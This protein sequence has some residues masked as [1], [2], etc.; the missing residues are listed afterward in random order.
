MPNNANAPD[1]ISWAAQQN[2]LNPSLV[3]S[4]IRAESSGNPNAVSPA[5]AQGLM[6]LM[7]GTARDLGVTN[8][9][10][11][12]D[13]AMGGI[14]YLG[15]MNSQ[16]GGD[17]DK[18]LAAYNFGP[19]N[20]SKGRAYPP[21]TQAYIQKVN[22][23]MQQ[24]GGSQSPSAEPPD[25]LDWA[26]TQNQETPAEQ[27]YS[28]AGFGEN[29]KSSAG[30]FLENLVHPITH[31]GE[32]VTGLKNLGLGVGEKLLPGE[33]EHEK[34]ANA[35]G[36]FYADR[37]GGLEKIQ[38]TLYTDPVGAAADVSM[39]FGGASMLPGKI[40]KIAATA[41]ELTN[42]LNAIMKPLAAG[43]RAVAEATMV[44]A[45]KPGLKLRQNYGGSR[46]IARTALDEGIVASDKGLGKIDAKRAG[47]AGEKASV[48]TQAMGAGHTANP[49]AI[50]NE[51]QRL[52]DKKGVG[53]QMFPEDDRAAVQSIM[54][55]WKE[56]NSTPVQGPV[57]QGQ[58]PLP[59]QWNAITD[60]LGLEAEKQGTYKSLNDAFRKLSDRP[61]TKQAEATAAIGAKNELE[62]ATQG[63]TS[64]GKNLE[65]LNQRDKRLHGVKDAVKGRMEQNGPSMPF[66][67]ILALLG[68]QGSY[69]L[70]ALHQLLG[71]AG[72]ASR[73]AHVIDKG[74]KVVGKV[75]P[76]AGLGM[77]QAALMSALGQ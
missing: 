44:Q 60:L 72:P 18:M 64:N 5:G 56:Q 21:E 22:A 4:V 48:E 74:S 17:S 49:E 1:F 54:D 47:I 16:F 3:D 39:L 53:V 7:P 35:A 10:D 6:Q 59:P 58:A 25:F 37:Y 62:N 32:T 69:P 41:S 29:L 73:A 15:Q 24:G 57:Q 27:G 65:Q 8:P 31:F 36:Q 23:G 55:K 70:I 43:G 76:K 2:K 71:R 75:L 52:M 30:S 38:K 50:Y 13:N 77:E 51:V 63:F 40:G 19:G 46:N 9:L 45:L 67:A 26:A 68:G 61:G 42:P 14:R 28:L 11:P 34:Y 66:D 33:Q 20:V 12:V